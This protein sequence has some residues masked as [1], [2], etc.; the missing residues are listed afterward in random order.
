MIIPD[1]PDI[2][3]FDW[4]FANV[5]KLLKRHKVSTIECEQVFFNEPFLIYEDTEHS[6]QELRYYSLG[7][8]NEYRHLT[9]IFTI[10]NRKIRP[11]S[12]RPMTKNEVKNYENIKKGT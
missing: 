1:F 7:V 2:E 5:H 6:I 11:L 12:A 4:D 8:T 9:V 3:V 10:R